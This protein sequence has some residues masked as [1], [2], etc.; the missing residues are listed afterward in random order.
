M[1]RNSNSQP[2]S[3]AAKAAAPMHPK[4]PV[5]RIAFY[6]SPVQERYNQLLE[7]IFWYQQE[8]GGFL[9]RDFRYDGERSISEEEV[10]AQPYPWADWQPHGLLAA[11][12]TEAGLPEWLRR[13]GLPFV[14]TSS[15][16]SGLVP[17]VHVA[18]ASLGDLAT[19]HFLERGFKHFAFVGV[20]DAFGMQI[21][22]AAFIK[23]LAGKGF[24]ALS[25][26]L[27]PRPT[28]G[29]T[30]EYDPTAEELVDLLSSAR[31][32]L[33]VLAGDDY[34][35]RAVCAAC[36]RQ[37]LAI[38]NQVAVLGVDDSSAA[39]F[40]LPPL[41]SIQPPNQKIGY[42]AMGNLDR[43]LN[44]EAPSCVP[45]EVP[46]TKLV[47]RQSTS[48]DL[49]DDEDVA[50]TLRLM[51]QRVSQG[52]NVEGIVAELEISRSTL[53]RKFAQ[54]MGCT[55]GEEL[56]RIRLGRAQELLTTTKMPVTQIAQMLGYHRASNFSD[57]FHKST[58]VSPRTYR[59]AHGGP[60]VCYGTAQ[61]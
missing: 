6:G 29:G 51:R 56:S 8:H 36:L 11:V 45:V 28:K 60:P 3:A 37:G 27:A 23:S 49:A 15:S 42:L 50:R 25:C 18:P 14:V 17:S 61:D 4:R 47:E 38:P 1:A 2:V 20:A 54:V 34:V 52:I 26:D 58:G 35:G 22:R 57:F 43:I 53:E 46:V 5:R 16:L 7:G 40:C 21:R 12:G 41:S 30:I 9:L 44:G 13:A 59:K 32:P 39:Q 33:A 31:K 24:T 19:R 55:P 10:L 48:L